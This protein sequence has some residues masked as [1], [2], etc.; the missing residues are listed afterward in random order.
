MYI[1]KE[2]PKKVETQKTVTIYDLH[3]NDHATLY[4][5]H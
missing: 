2:Q 4:F 3:N 1:Y 5:I